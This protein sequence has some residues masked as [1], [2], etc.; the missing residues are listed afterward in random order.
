MM[1]VIQTKACYDKGKALYFKCFY[2]I[3]SD[4]FVNHVFKIE[5]AISQEYTIAY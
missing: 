4:F 2:L 5:V 3:L 1:F